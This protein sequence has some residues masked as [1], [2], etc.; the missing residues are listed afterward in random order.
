LNE[1]IIIKTIELQ[2][3]YKVKL[4]DAVIAATELVFDLALITH[5]IADFKNIEG[6]NLIDS[7]SI[8]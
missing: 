1:D 6:L 8:I 5:D 3:K 4:P 2:K 7:H